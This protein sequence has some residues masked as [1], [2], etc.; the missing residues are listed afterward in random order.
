MTNWEKIVKKS[1]RCRFIYWIR[2]LFPFIF[3]MIM[4]DNKRPNQINY[5]LMALN[6]PI[7]MLWNVKHLE[8]PN[9]A[10]DNYKKEVYTA[11]TERVIKPICRKVEEEIRV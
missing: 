6:D 9:V 4:A 3:D 11:F 1:T 7:D 2:S 8:S 5:F 10:V